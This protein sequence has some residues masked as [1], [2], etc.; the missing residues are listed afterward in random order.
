MKPYSNF[1]A[2]QES[3]PASPFSYAVDSLD[4]RE[5]Y[6]LMEEFRDANVFQTPP[7]N[8][9]KSP[10]SKVERFVVTQGSEIVAATLVRLTSV[11]GIGEVSAYVRWGPLWQRRDRDSQPEVWRQAIR[12]LH[13][14]YVK[15]RRMWLRLFPVLTV[16]ESQPFLS[17][18][19]SEGFVSIDTDRRLRTMWV[20]LTP[21]LDQLRTG[22]DK[23]WR[24]CLSAAERNELEIVSGVEDELFEQFLIPYREMWTRKGI[25][26]LG[27]IHGFRKMQESLPPKH[28]M[29]V[30]L[31]FLQGTVCAGGVASAIGDRG[32]YL[33]GAT[34]DK[35]T[36]TKA[37]YLIQWRIVEWL[38][39]QHC[40]EYDLHGV[41]RVTN[42]GGYTFKEG[43][44]GK[45][46]KEIEYYG[47]FDGYAG[48]KSYLVAKAADVGTAQ[49]A[50]VRGVY[51]TWRGHKD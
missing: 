50:K 42:P 2:V 33:F 11:P 35:A 19:E 38:K 43:L 27:D 40:T 14:E 16:E 44:C 36:A 18:L 20:D 21:P 26:E 34:G 23:K 17:I 9:V 5:W 32:L 10:Q 31:C 8:A 4:D 49:Y 13:L 7:F 25:A 22:L 24:N 12:L 6:H 28:K 30:F 15:R 46:G 41:N 29:R 37:S 51:R 45:N 39:E 47:R 48:L 1:D 3:L